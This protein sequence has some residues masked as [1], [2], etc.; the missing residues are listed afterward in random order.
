MT[1]PLG[2]DRE[3]TTLEEELV[4]Y[5]DDELDV[6]ARERLER[7]LADEP[8]IRESLR[9]LTRVWDALET[10]PRAEVDEAFA[11]TT[12][13]AVVA[14]ETLSQANSLANSLGRN[15]RWWIARGAAL[16]VCLVAGFALARWLWPDPNV[17]LAK[18]LPIL[19][20]LDDYRAARDVEF[21]RL[22]REEGMFSDAS[23]GEATAPRLA[24]DDET[25]F[26]ANVARLAEMEDYDDERA[27]IAR[28][29]REFDEFGVVEQARLRMLEKNLRAD[30][31][32]AELRRLMTR[33]REWLATLSTGQ[34]SEIRQIGD[35]KQRIVRMREMIA[36]ELP[37]E[38]D[39]RVVHNWI[40]DTARSKADDLEAIAKGK[41]LFPN[42]DAAKENFG[43]REAEAVIWRAVATDQVSLLP[44][45]E[46][47]FH[48]LASK[49][50]PEPKERL[51]ECDNVEMKK[52]VLAGWMETMARDFGKR[53][54]MF[55]RRSEAGIDYAGLLKDDLDAAE[56]YEIFSL[57]PEE[58]ERALAGEW[59][60]RYGEPPFGGPR[61]PESRDGER[62]R[63][64]RH[65]HDDDDD[66]DD[67]RRGERRERKLSEEKT[68][69]AAVAGANDHE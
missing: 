52:L 60:R 13:E 6:E 50:S 21:L 19:E 15:R 53:F 62:R 8:K 68:K 65:D 41:T 45:D 44:F 57:P 47:D 51:E 49:L 1:A 56:K 28:R 24:Q 61:G 55:G 11:T 64:G 20:R 38:E 5:L 22:L 58:A 63:G 4:A 36:A 34:Q 39:R 48:M 12:V 14:K 69:D 16:A 3:P 33:Y 17:Q 35:L 9:K 32:Q 54:R 26:K 59:F 67:H 18:D 37:E 43:G 27:A 30:P 10:L 7:R 42:L 23:A 40:R 25:L 66:D 29:M 2:H 31:N 46:F